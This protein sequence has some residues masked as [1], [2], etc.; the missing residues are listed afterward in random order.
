V[1][2]ARGGGGASGTAAAL[3]HVPEHV[4]VRWSAVLDGEAPDVVAV[5]GLVVVANRDRRSTLV[6]YD[7]ASGE[8]RWT[9]HLGRADAMGEVIA[10]DDALA[11][12]TVGRIPSLQLLDATTGEQRWRR[13]LRP[14]NA[15]AELAGAVVLIE[16]EDDG[17]RF[18]AIDPATGDAL[19][20]T[21]QRARFGASG[22]VRVDGTS[23]DVFDVQLSPVARDVELDAVPIDAV[24]VGDVV[25]VS[26]PGE[27]RAI[28][29]TGRERWRL[30]IDPADARYLLPSGAQDG[31]LLV[32]STST[33]TAIDVRGAEPQVVWT[34]EGLPLID[35]SS[36]GLRHVPIQTGA[37]SGEMRVL[38]LVDGVIAATVDL[39]G[40][41]A[42]RTLYGQDGAVLVRA[43]EDG[44]WALRAIDYDGGRTRWEA[45][46]R[47]E[48]TLVED[49]V[50]GVA[51]A[52]GATTITY[53][54]AG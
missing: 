7:A 51:E 16:P 11:V 41:A 34:V 47:G 24:V 26:V 14:V 5:D 1:L 31:H 28:E 40:T 43:G 17:V 30:P 29:L 46:L 6:A 9:T 39:D 12:T 53:L 38:D 37:G 33:T 18:V 20:T 44:A 49:G 32:V 36:P 45:V 10:L 21:D 13:R 25:V 23:A 27:L 35:P 15:V 48:P 50:V 54:G 4:D 2:V 3:P 19:G 42:G 52:D 8:V 22:A